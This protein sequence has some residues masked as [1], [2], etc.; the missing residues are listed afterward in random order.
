MSVR[1]VKRLLQQTSELD[2]NS[3][4][5]NEREKSRA[6]HRSKRK[7]AKQAPVPVDEKEVVRHQVESLL[8]LDRKV[9]SKNSKKMATSAR[10]RENQSKQRHIEKSTAKKVL[11]N[12]RSA[13]SALITKPVPTFNKKKYNKQ[14]EEKRLAQIAKLLKKNSAKK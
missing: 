4:Q 6:S 9:S 5:E 11:G 8:F 7:H 1:L 13:S 12:T 2:A 14:K 3:R 10:L